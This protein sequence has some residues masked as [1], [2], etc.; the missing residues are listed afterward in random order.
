M[1]STNEDKHELYMQTSYLLNTRC[2]ILAEIQH[3]TCK[4]KSLPQ[5]HEDLACAHVGRLCVLNL[6]N[7]QQYGA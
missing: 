6:S 4:H 7:D 5:M 1:Y 2:D 3:I